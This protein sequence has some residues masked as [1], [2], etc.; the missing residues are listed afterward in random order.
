MAHS[1]YPLQA[2]LYSVAVHRYLRWRL[3]GYSPEVHLGGIGYLFVRGMV[4][5]HT[6][7]ADGRPY[8]V[9]QWRPPAA[10]V[11]ALDSLFAEGA[12]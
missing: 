5:A 8:G 7:N 6:P 1:D 2:L 11:V 9:F 12:A 3:P 4:G 10:T